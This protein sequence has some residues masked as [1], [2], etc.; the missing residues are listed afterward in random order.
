MRHLI[1]L[2]TVSIL[3]TSTA[4]LAQDA[5]PVVAPATEAVPDSS[6]EGRSAA[7]AGDDWTAAN[8]FEKE[9]AERSTPQ[10]RFNL[11]ASYATTDRIEA[12]IELYRSAARDGEFLEV[13][14]DVVEG[15]TQRQT[16]VNLAEE[17]TRRADALELLNPGIAAEVPAEGS[18]AA[19]AAS[20]D[21]EANTTD[22]VVDEH[23]SDAVAVALDRADAPVGREGPERANDRAVERSNANVGLRTG[24]TTTR[25][26]GRDERA[27]TAELNRQ[28]AQGRPIT[29]E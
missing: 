3:L 19:E 24:A 20:E 27:V 10:A 17:A 15:S 7:V 14:L 11:A 28:S 4:V 2:T 6:V 5:A 8:I 1:A 13:Q 9:N 23:V 25:M 21:P 16:G 18:A 22:I 26:T 29:G 12:A